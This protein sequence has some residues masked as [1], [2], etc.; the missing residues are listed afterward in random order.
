MRECEGFGHIQSKYAN[1]LKKNKK[2]MTTTWSDQD[3]ESSDEEDNVNL[4]LISV[5]SSLTLNLQETGR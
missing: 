3:S 2:V 4:A 1:T 5:V